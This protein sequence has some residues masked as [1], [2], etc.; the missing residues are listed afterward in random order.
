MHEYFGVDLQLTWRVATVEICELKNRMLE[1]K[2]D[3]EA[4]KQQGEE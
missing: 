2:R 3:L 1:I 4:G